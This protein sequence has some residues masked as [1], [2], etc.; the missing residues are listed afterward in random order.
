MNIV[1]STD[2]SQG[3]EAM[4]TRISD[5]LNA[6]RKAL[7]LVCGGSNISVAAK[8]ME[9]IR[10]RT[11]AD[12]ISSLTVGL[13]DERYGAVG[14]KDSNWQQL[15]DARINLHKVSLM[16]VLIGK[17]LEATVSEYNASLAM[18]IKNLHDNG[19][20]VIAMFGIG[21]DGHIA[22]ILPHTEAA[23]EMDR[24]ATGYKAGPYIR[25]TMTLKAIEH[26]DTAY[27]FVFS[28]GSTTKEAMMQRLV[29]ED[30]DLEEQPAQIMKKL[31]EANLYT[32][33]D[34]LN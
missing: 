8:A 16:P 17:S 30:L 13:T 10:V 12:A 4:A 14:H 33:I 34:N 20:L 25:I 11:K 1:H 28:G 18:K 2:P 22:G 5:A 29:H 6:G 7:W 24:L 31:A 15:V 3:I 32:D 23:E 21:A 27:A 9:R 19:G 26:V